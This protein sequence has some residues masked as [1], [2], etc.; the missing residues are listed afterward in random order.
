MVHPSETLFHA[1]QAYKSSTKYVIEWL[2]TTLALASEHKLITTTNGVV[3]AAQKVALQ[4]NEVPISVISTLQRCIE[5]RKAVTQIY[6]SQSA[7]MHETT[8]L[9]NHGH[10]AFVER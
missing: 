3:E 1:Y 5:Q 10:E 2:E 4:V 7:G 6:K 9:G 8:N